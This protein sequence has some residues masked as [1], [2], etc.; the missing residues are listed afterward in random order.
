MIEVFDGPTER[1]TIE[2]YD[3]LMQP[4]NENKAEFFPHVTILNA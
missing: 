4:Y 1:I 3:Q 2:A